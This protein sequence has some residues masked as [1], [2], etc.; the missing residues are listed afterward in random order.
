MFSIII[1]YKPDGGIRDKTFKY[2]HNYYR[3]EFLF[4]E[5]Y[6]V[7]I[8][9][10]KDKTGKQEFN[11]SNAINNGVKK[12]NG[13]AL[14]IVG[15]DTLIKRTTLYKAVDMLDHSPFVIPF[16]MLVS[17]DKYFSQ[18]LMESDY[19]DIN[20]NQLKNYGESVSIAPGCTAHIPKN[21]GVQVMTL[22]LFYEM[23]GYE[24]KFNGWGYEDLHFCW[25][26][27]K[28]YG[29]YPLLNN[30][31]IYHLWHPRPK[32]S[33]SE[34]YQR[35]AQLFKELGGDVNDFYKVHRELHN[36]WMDEVLK[37]VEKTDNQSLLTE[38]K[39][40]WGIS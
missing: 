32:Q 23:G 5:S 28:E 3:Q 29:D 1:P 26:V 14:F 31:C 17:L 40:E 21:S 30:E 2:I 39:R 27:L 38:L 20:F 9:I 10:G 13:D 24:E 6:N 7:E 34:A 18:V 15:A 19:D 37:A 16:D 12:S 8:I 22:D 36:R 35:N 33:E 4:N 11:C 25:K